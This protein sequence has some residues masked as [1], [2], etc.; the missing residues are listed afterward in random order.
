MST[1]FSNNGKAGNESRLPAKRL[2]ENKEVK[3]GLLNST[4]NILTLRLSGDSPDDVHLFG[5]LTHA[6]IQV[7]MSGELPEE[8]CGV[9]GEHV[10][11][12][13]H[14]AK[15]GLKF[16]SL[17]VNVLIDAPLVD[18]DSL[19]AALLDALSGGVQA[20]GGKVFNAKL[21]VHSNRLH[22]L[23]TF[24]RYNALT[25]A[26]DYIIIISHR[27]DLVNMILYKF[28]KNFRVI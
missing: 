1:T 12:L 19:N 14:D 10:T 26:A 25:G 13:V 2:E 5:G 20:E 17:G 8:R 16:A 7:D 21:S 3:Y 22:I 11:A 28:F 27:G 15:E 6:L 4:R 23:L 24:S 18:V 9:G